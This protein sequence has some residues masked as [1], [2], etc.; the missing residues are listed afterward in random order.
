LSVK[1]DEYH[2]MVSSLYYMKDVILN[3]MFPKLIGV[4]NDYDDDLCW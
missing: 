3:F 4:N 1:F 2:D